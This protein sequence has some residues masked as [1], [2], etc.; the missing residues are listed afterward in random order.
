MEY[1]FTL[2]T[3]GHIDHGKTALVRAMTGVDCDRLEEEKRR[4]ITIELGFAPLALPSGRVVSIVDVPGH[5]R[6]IRQM[7]AGASGIDAVLFVVACDEGVMP[8]TREHLDILSLLGIERGIVAMTKRD[9][10]DDETFEMARDDVRSLLAGTFLDGAPLFAVSSQSGDGV[11]DLIEEIDR[12][13]AESTPRPRGGHFFMP[14]DRAFSVRGFGTVVT[15][16]IWRGT[17]ADGDDADIMPSSLRTKVRGI[18]VH[19]GAT[20]CAGAGQRAAINLASVSLAE[21]SRG[22]VLCAAGMYSATDCPFAL[23][24][25]LPTARPL[26][27]WQRVHLH[28]GSA[29]VV[30]RVSLL[31]GMGDD[32][33]SATGGIVS[34]LV[35]A[36]P[37]TTLIGQRFVLRSYSPLKTIGGGTILAPARERAQG[38]AERARIASALRAYASD[39]R[40][41][42]LLELL[43]RLTGSISIRE[44]RSASQMD[45]ADFARAA[46]RLKAERADAVR[47]FADTFMSAETADDA[48]GRIVAAIARFHTERPELAGIDDAS[49]AN[50]FSQFDPRTLD[51]MLGDL[52]S[53]GLIVKTASGSAARY[54]A[55]DFAGRSDALSEIA[56]GL[57]AEVEASAWDL[58]SVDDAAHLIDAPRRDIDRAV[59]M[60]REA[61]R[62]R[63]ITG[64][65]LLAESLR[66]RALS[67]LRAVDGDITLPKFR[68]AIGA[69]RKNALAILE[70]F[71]ST[72]T[73]RRVG[74][75]RVLLRKAGGG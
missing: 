68:D 53:R 70:H 30:A 8:Q 38:G 23:I 28:I 17:I 3:A 26:E 67:T 50:A 74:D 71:D 43:I 44:L 13:V 25:M 7:T 18:Q 59:A 36:E 33:M 34:Q 47:V 56:D 57:L 63:V 20:S 35:A 61:G 2:G 69:S 54:A 9:T 55:A 45:D 6:F 11:S 62:L 66:E 21:L 27:H 5:E 19:G 14:I 22:D 42:S 15:G 73:T 12:M 72:E 37:I 52:T 58:I 75:R 1:P 65:M 48:L 46:G 29:D 41:Q 60:L 39:M 32:S 4:G 51:A 24:E 31:D 64:G 10:V 16:T 40:P 49:L